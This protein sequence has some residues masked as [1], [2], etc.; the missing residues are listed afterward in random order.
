MADTAEIIE[1]PQTEVAVHYDL[2]DLTFAQRVALDP[3]IDIERLK[4]VIEMENAA[5]DRE[6]NKLF[7][8][9][10]AAMQPDLPAVA[11]AGQGQNNSEFAKLEAIQA[12]ARPILQNHGF[13]YRFKQQDKEGAITLRCTLSHMSGGS[14]FDEMTLPY[15]VGGQKNAV[16]ARGSTV[17]YGKRY[18]LCNVL[19]IQLGGDDND[20]QTNRS[21]ETLTPD[22]VKQVRDQLEKLG[23]NDDTILTWAGQRGFGATDLENVPAEAFEKMIGQLNHW[24]KVRSKANG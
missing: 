2:E 23:Q 3:S 22:Q 8:A 11:K 12:A 13:S 1:A 17:S 15:D 20:G 4:A 5:Q 21:G 9:A 24:V 18:T 10:F 16:Q 14:D 7:E 6:A 19:G